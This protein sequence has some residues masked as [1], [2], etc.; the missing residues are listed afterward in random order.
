[1]MLKKLCA[2]WVFITACIIT[3]AQETMQTD[4]E[5]PT[6]FKFRAVAEI[7]FLG[8]LSN[9]I[10]FGNSGTYFNYQQEG[11]QDVLFPVSRLSLELDFK[12]R[13]TLVL[14]YQPLRLETQVL[15]ENDLIVDELLF[16]ASSNV[17]TLY[18]FPFYRLSYLRELLPRSTKFKLSVGGSLQIRNTTITFESGDGELFRTNRNV[19]IVPII[20]LRGMAQLNERMFAAIEADGFYA[21]V[22][23]L[24]GSDNE[25]IGAILDAS[26]RTG[27]QVTKEVTSF[28]NL[29]YLGGGAVGT[30]ERMEGPG[31]GFT[32]N[33][34]NFITVSAG[35]VYAF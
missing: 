31:D 32:R 27:L 15:L 30:N 17:K 33:W 3:N 20:K 29:R 4:M 26:F 21:P 25:I 12:K 13:N 6:N 28:L 5:T 22:S 9:Q 14:M 10:Q 24:N 34:L 1:M 7:G 23:Y 16:P 2:L 8:V 18:N 19:G 11:G 35:F